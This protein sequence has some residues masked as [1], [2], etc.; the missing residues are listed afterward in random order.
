MWILCMSQLEEDDEQWE[1]YDNAIVET[2]SGRVIEIPD[3][4]DALDI[5]HWLNIA[6]EPYPKN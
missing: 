6:G 4:N 5:C 3:E 1:E 2:E